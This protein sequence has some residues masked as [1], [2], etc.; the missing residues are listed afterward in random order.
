MASIQ[1]A[2]LIGTIQKKGGNFDVEGLTVLVDHSVAPR[3]DSA[4]GLERAAGSVTE[5]LARLQRRLFS[6]HAGP[7]D[8]FEAS[9]AVGNPPMAMD[10]LDGAGAEI[11]D[12]DRVEPKIAIVARL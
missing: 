9:F 2:P 7:F 11:G 10:Q 8:L 5:G 3:H 12:L 6:Y 1:H 4:R